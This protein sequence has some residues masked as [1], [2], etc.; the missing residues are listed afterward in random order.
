MLRDMLKRYLVSCS[1]IGIGSPVQG[2]FP[3]CHASP[4]SCHEYNDSDHGKHG[5]KNQYQV[6]TQEHCGLIHRDIPPLLVPGEGVYVGGVCI[7][8]EHSISDALSSSN[9]SSNV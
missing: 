6:A 5:Q 3:F 9:M 4:Y 8:E 1:D 7:I 2:R